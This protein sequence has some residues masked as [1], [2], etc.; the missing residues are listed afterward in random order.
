MMGYLYVIGEYPIFFES[1]FWIIKDNVRSMKR[2]IVRN[3]AIAFLFF[4]SHFFSSLSAQPVQQ[5]FS[6]AGAHTRN[7]AKQLGDSSRI[8]V[9]MGKDSM[10]QWADLYDWRSGFFAGNIWFLYE[11]TKDAQW[12][13]EAR[14]WT[15]ALEPLQF[16]KDHH[17]LGFMVYCSYGAGYRLTGDE[18]YKKII[19]EAARS[20]CTRYSEK[21]KAIKSWNSFRSWTS[22]T[23][24]HYPVIIDNMMNLELLFFA[25]RVTGD[26]YFRNV[27]IAHAN[28]TL[29]DHFRKDYSAYHV[30]FYDTVTGKVLARETAQGY[31]HESA[32]SRGQAWALYGFTTTYRETKDE[33][34]LQQARGI[35]RYLMNHPRLPADNIPLWDYDAGVPGLS[36]VTK[37]A[38]RFN[39]GRQPSDASAAA[40]IASA[41]L[42]LSGYVPRKEGAGMVVFA[43]NI[44][45]SLSG[46]EYLAEP[47]TNANFLLKHS[48]GSLAHGGEIDVPLI[49]ADYYFLEALLRWKEKN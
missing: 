27:A 19:V 5:L 32:W 14:R 37:S 45:R 10:V 17:D 7:M 11:Y 49:Y 6:M 39:G 41:L 2:R 48:V 30:V 44:L 15:A 46:P 18:N 38:G 3:T 34:Y 31:A 26:P 28:T 43:G 1:E 40:I 22:G 21:T 29:K 47:G 33:R 36:P 12:L 16:F 42:E 8:P 23:T 20:L 35:A 9:A 24:Y 25:S 13:K 4:L